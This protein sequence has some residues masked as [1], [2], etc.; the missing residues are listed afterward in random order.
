MEVF[1]K[2]S[3]KEIPRTLSHS[4]KDVEK[5][6]E[7]MNRMVDPNVLR[8]LITKRKYRSKKVGRE[9]ITYLDKINQNRVNRQNE[10]KEKESKNE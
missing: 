1:E 10:D 2:D 7:E 6:V 5:I 8:F 9:Y 4:K 3:W